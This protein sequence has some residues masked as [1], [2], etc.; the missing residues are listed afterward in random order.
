MPVLLPS[1]SS[2]KEPSMRRSMMALARSVQVFS[3]L[4]EEAQQLCMEHAEYVDVPLGE[5]LFQQ[6]EYDGS[7][8]AVLTGSIVTRFHDHIVGNDD[9]E[10]MGETGSPTKKKN[11]SVNKFT[12]IHGKR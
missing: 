12:S 3:Y 5:C 1:S 10:G 7:L 2:S 11:K 8:Y 6:S 9:E 4:G